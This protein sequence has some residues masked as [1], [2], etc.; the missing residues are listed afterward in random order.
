MVILILVCVGSG[1]S[2]HLTNAYGMTNI[3]LLTRLCSCQRHDCH[4]YPSRHGMIHRLGIYCPHSC[5]LPPHLWHYRW[6]LLRRNAQ[7]IPPRRLVSVHGRCHYVLFHGV[8][9]MGHGKETRTISR[10][11]ESYSS[12]GMAAEDACSSSNVYNPFM[13]INV[14]NY[15]PSFASSHSCLCHIKCNDNNIHFFSHIEISICG[16]TVLAPLIDQS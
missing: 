13:S 11:T 5:R 7:Q 3:S 15:T 16:C 8:S 14:T 12:P 10:R 6:R 9:E 1:R 4:H 2:G